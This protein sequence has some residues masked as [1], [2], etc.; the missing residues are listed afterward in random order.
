MQFIGG[1][2]ETWSRSTATTGDLHVVSLAHDRHVQQQFQSPVSA[3]LV[4]Q[5]VPCLVRDWVPEHVMERVKNTYLDHADTTWV[6]FALGKLPTDLTW[7]IYRSPGVENTYVMCWQMSPVTIWLTGYLARIV[8]VV[9]TQDNIQHVHVT[10]QLLRET[11]MVV[12]QQ[13][14][15]CSGVADSYGTNNLNTIA[16]YTPF[17]D[18]YRTAQ[19]DLSEKQFRKVYEIGEQGQQSVLPLSELMAGDLVLV[20]ANFRRVSQDPHTPDTAPAIN[21]WFEMEAM[22]RIC[23]APV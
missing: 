11:D 4:A 17:A 22:Y 21:V 9:T 2:E 15:N 23:S 6:V 19:G 3:I 13:C 7:G 8:T 1:R 16:A 12:L 5:P 10:L 14:L 18:V 20:R